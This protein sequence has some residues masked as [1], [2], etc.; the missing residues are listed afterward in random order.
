MKLPRLSSFDWVLTGTVVLLVLLG[1]TMVLSTTSDTVLISPRFIRQTVAFLIGLSVYGVVS[2]TP[3]HLWRP[4]APLLYV[5]GLILLLAAA[6]LT[7]VIRG[8]TSRLEVVFGLQFQPSEFMKIPL[9]L[10]L[11]WY[12]HPRRAA[13]PTILVSAGL[14]AIVAALVAREPD[15]GVA[16]LLMISWL[17]FIVYLGAPWRL[18][19]LLAAAGM[20]IT[21]GTWQGLLADYQKQ[22]VLTFLDPATDPL[23]AG[24]NITQ[25]LV[26]LG[27]GGLLGRG[28]G[29]GPQSQLKFLPEQH[30]DFIVASIGEELGFVGITLLISLYMLMLWR[31]NHIARSTR[32]PFGQYLAALVFLLLLSSFG[33]NAGMNMGLLPI[34]GLPLPLVSYGGSSLLATLVLLG[35]AQSVNVHNT[36]V[37]TPPVELA[38]LS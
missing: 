14:V 20:L 28:L 7:P 4:Y 22:R 33:V 35:L 38:Y 26:A 31:I 17:G 37:R 12:F 6:Q 18:L 25:S 9:V 32:D 13:T 34:T 27:S 36:W 19:A 15:L 1:M 10:M 8:T 24:Y 2:L 29:H 21:V 3:Y 11:A 5:I 30:T 23:G 16:V